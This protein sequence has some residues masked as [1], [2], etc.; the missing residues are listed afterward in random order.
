MA[1]KLNNILRC[2][3]IRT[4][5]M[6]AAG[7]LQSLAF[8]CQITARHISEHREFIYWYLRFTRQ[9]VS[10]LRCTVMSILPIEAA[11]PSEFNLPNYTAKYLR[12]IILS[13]V[14]GDYTRRGLDYQ[15]DLLVLDKDTLNHSVY[16]SQPTR[17]WVS[18][19]SL[20]AGNH[21]YGIPCHH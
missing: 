5:K 1:V 19:T 2:F 11:G 10:R 12:R 18:L 17:S 9:W 20:Q 7:S 15:L 13:R 14:Y 8:I 4:L 6:E 3:V 21:S 16:T